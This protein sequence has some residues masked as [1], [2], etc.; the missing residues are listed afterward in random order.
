MIGL[1]A[2]GIPLAF[3]FPWA[4]LALL[5]LPVIWWLLRLTPPRPAREPFPPT[6]ILSELANHEETPA[7]S[8]WWLTL[9]RLMMAALIIIAMA[10][11]V[12]NPQN[13]SL[14]GEGPM[15]LVVDNGWASGS[16]WD[17]LLV[18]A[19]TII[20]QAQASDRQII[21][22]FTARDARQKIE[23]AP[24]TELKNNLSS[25]INFPNEPDYLL[26]AK[27]VAEANRLYS[28]SSVVFLSEGLDYQGSDELS[29]RLQ[30]RAAQNILYLP[31]GDN[32]IVIDKLR[33]E[34][35]AMSGKIVRANSS[36]PITVGLV[37]LDLNGVS[38]TRKLVTFGAGEK[39]ID[40]RFEIPVELRN[41]IVRVVIDGI[42]NAGAVQ[43]LDESNRRRLV[44]L[45]SGEKY[46]NAQPLLSPL[47]YISSALEPFS[48]IRRASDANVVMAV[49]ELI[50]S[51]VST[52]VLADVGVL[53]PQ[54]SNRLQE[55]VNKGG[56]LIRFAG[57]RLAAAQ[58][59]T[60]LPVR[61]RLG[62]RNI[63]GALS[64]EEPKPVA[65]FEITSPFFGLEPPQDVFVSRQVLAIQEGDL[66]NKTWARLTDGTPLVTASRNGNGWI[67]LFHVSSDASWSNLPIS[68]TFVE[69]LRRV[70]NQSRSSFTAATTEA[71]LALPPLR[72]LNGKGQLSPPGV[73]VKPAIFD[74]QNN[75]K[76][77]LENP[78]GFYGTPDGFRA[79]N[80]F[81]ADAKLDQLPKDFLGE[82]SILAK[83]AKE[84]SLSLKP[85][86][87]FSVALLLIL[88]CLAVLWMAGQLR[89]LKPASR[90]ANAAK[91]STALAVIV[92]A[93]LFA[94]IPNITQAQQATPQ[95]QADVID[96]DFDFSPALRTR[97]AYVITGVAEID[98]TSEAGLRGLTK[99]L[100]ERTAIEPGEPI[101]VDISKDELAFYPMIYWPIDTASNL[102]DQQTMARI[103]AYMKQGGSVLFDTRDRVSGLL[104]GTS[105]SPQALHLQQIL[106]SLDIPPLEPVPQDH[107]LTKS[108]FILAQ[109]P[110]RYSG[111][112]L[113]VE[114]QF[115]A[116]ERSDRPVRAGDGVSS[117]LITSN[118]LAGAWAIDSQNRPMFPIVPPDP[119]QR[120]IAF[121]V[122]VNLVMYAM[123]G[124]YKSDQVHIPALLQRLGQ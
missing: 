49:P 13:S 120:E 34:P 57:P 16:E 124:N 43:L 1:S 2:L 110:G 53:P 29:A 37:A 92:A 84:Q 10:L 93:G 47:N 80:L 19:G 77:S 97:L 60:L 17:Q 98:E 74:D 31:D 79:L 73:E 20:D 4:L 56:M 69:M 105:S 68:G 66:A 96:P 64:W 18:T 45:I 116:V 70:V 23:V 121:R 7:R 119:I 33:N 12:W 86:A 87:L 95:T 6:K 46:D 8:P 5:S 102:P 122:G 55:W 3:A 21:T 32:T 108:F 54:T 50:T 27:K 90:S 67:V 35:D 48:D 114:R 63:G 30:E 62:N 89:F 111:G 22:I 9:L 78:P 11:P 81:N 58:T 100:T 41:D 71:S 76:V 40:F 112:E 103:D 52:I 14:K 59:T 99:F 101:G 36:D 72:L 75:L 85:W 51:G 118:D 44:G 42:E 61:L 104:G 91:V 115:D 94:V 123:T 39:S 109:F 113:W 83:Y 106:A 65:E 107:V 25:W 88:D 15:M 38:I 26:T 28:P 117:I 24:A 82:N